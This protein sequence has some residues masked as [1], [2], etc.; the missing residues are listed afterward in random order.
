M[1][2]SLKIYL[3]CHCFLRKLE[4]VDKMAESH[5][6]WFWMCGE[7]VKVP[8]RRVDQ[9]ECNSIA[10]DRG[11]LRKTNGETIGMVY[12]RI[13]W[14]GLIHVADPIKWNNA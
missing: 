1:D 3:M 12:N 11:R 13:L 4:F 5:L 9:I 7:L 8:V 14:Y 2:I 6:K 10:R